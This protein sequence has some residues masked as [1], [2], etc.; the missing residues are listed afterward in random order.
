MSSSSY[1]LTSR[2]EA[3]RSVVFELGQALSRS[4]RSE[5]NMAKREHTASID[6]TSSIQD[7]TI[8]TG[9]RS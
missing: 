7:R 1:D 4:V 2:V 6:T 3:K 8:T 5:D 9:L